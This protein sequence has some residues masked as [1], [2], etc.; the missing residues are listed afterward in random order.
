[1]R[2]SLITA[3][4]LSV[5]CTAPAA[6]AANTDMGTLTINGHVKGTTCHFESNAQSAKI[7]MSQIGTDAIKDLQVGEAYDGYKNETITPFTVTCDSKSDIPKLKFHSNEFEGAGDNGVTKNNGEADGVGY[8]LLINGD[9]INVDG[10]TQIASTKSADGK[11]T[12][13]IAAQYAR[14]NADTISAGSVNSVV[15]F[16]VVAD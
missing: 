1:M 10:E 14:A 13:N 7:Q 6:F 16:T 12:F 2:K 4:I 9:R 5:C 8:A 15:T 11:Y 3:A